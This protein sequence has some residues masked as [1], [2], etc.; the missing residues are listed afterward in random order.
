MPHNFRTLREY[1]VGESIYIGW[2]IVN[3]AVNKQ[4]D[5]QNSVAND[6][7]S[8]MNSSVGLLLGLFLYIGFWQVN[9]N[10]DDKKSTKYLATSDF[11]F[12]FYKELAKSTEKSKNII[13][14]PLSIYVAFAMLKAGASRNT[15]H[16]METVL[17][18][19]KLIEKSGFSDGHSAVRSLLA[20][21]FTPL[22]KNNTIN[23]ANKL[24]MQKYFCSKSCDAFVA[25]LQRNYNTTLAELN[26]AEEAEKCRKEINKWVEDKTNDK[27]KN[28]LPQ[29]SVT[30]LTRFVLTNAIYFKSNW[31]SKFDKKH[32]IMRD[33]NTLSGQDGSETKKVP[34]MYQ[35]AEVYAAGFI[36]ASEYQLLELPYENKD[37]SMLIILPPSMRDFHA[38]ERSLSTSKLNQMLDE[39]YR[40]PIL[41]FNVYLP[42]FKVT[43]SITLNEKLQKMGMRDVFDASEADLSGITGYKALY[44]SSA[45]HKAFIKVD[46]EGTEAAASTGIIVGVK[47][48]PFQFNINRPF[49]FM[50]RHKPTGTVLFMGRVMDPSQET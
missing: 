30:S 24:W 7:T 22:E 8:A 35:N 33:F 38:I 21:V 41:S 12:N 31:K 44:V 27:I 49:M 48:L 46:E 34:T 37:L 14:S 16:E 29:G 25:K 3:I 10:E 19:Q 40:Y 11:A 4:I 2:V 50:I 32:T 42:K 43:T 45:V 1:T 6:R 47:S 18:W 20:E 13:F 23:I 39:L 17:K 28:L 15:K 26:F 9:C 36:P 5:L